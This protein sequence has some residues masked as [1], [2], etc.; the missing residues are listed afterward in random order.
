MRLLG[1]SIRP[2][3]VE[4]VDFCFPPPTRFVF[5]AL[6]WGIQSQASFSFNS[7]ALDSNSEEV[8]FQIA[9][10][11]GSTLLT[12][13]CAQG[14]LKKWISFSGWCEIEFYEIGFGILGKI[15]G[16]I[17]PPPHVCRINSRADRLCRFYPNFY[18]RATFIFYSFNVILYLLILY[19]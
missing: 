18:C 11:P 16:N 1:W 10:L 4:G 9:L 19:Y 7:S 5:F 13:H 2:S 6:V 3:L 12:F 14:S 17:V 15:R 8:E